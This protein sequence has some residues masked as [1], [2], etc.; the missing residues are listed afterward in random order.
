[1]DYPEQLLRS[2]DFLW[3][4]GIA[5]GYNSFIGPVEFSVSGANRNPG[6]LFFLNI[7]YWF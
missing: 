7:G 2:K 1:V 5:A 4:Y 6:L 3:G